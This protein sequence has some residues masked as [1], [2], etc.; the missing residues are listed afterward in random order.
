MATSCETMSKRTI[1]CAMAFFVDKIGDVKLSKAISEMLL[2]ASELVTPRF[3]SLQIIKHGSTAKAP[4]N[5][6]ESAN[7]ITTMID[8]YGMRDLPLKEIIDFAKFATT[9]ANPQVRT[10][11]MKL[12]CEIYRHVGDVIRNF[13]GDIKDST[14]KMIDAD[15]DKVE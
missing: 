14:L 1:Q 2:N 7:T 10:A 12:F 15:L 5:I 8:E 6:Q 4:K 3:I 13:M 9:N 11:A